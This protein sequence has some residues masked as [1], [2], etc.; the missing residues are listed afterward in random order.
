MAAPPMAWIVRKLAP[1]EPIT[2][3]AFPT[4]VGMSWSLMS[5]KT[6]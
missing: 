2:R 1:S 6:W 5:R 3:A 4:V